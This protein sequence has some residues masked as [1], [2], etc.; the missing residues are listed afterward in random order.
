MTREKW[1][2]IK[3]KVLD[4]F[5]IIDKGVEHFDEEGGVDVDFVEFTSPLGKTRLEF[6]EKPLVTGKKTLYS[7]RG[8]SDTGV[9]FVY[10]PTEKSSRM[11][12]YKWDENDSNWVEIEGEKFSF[13]G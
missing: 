3:G 8:G 4:A 7:H 13:S 9:E 1:E 12:A 10:S 11:K 2:A 5:E 6:V